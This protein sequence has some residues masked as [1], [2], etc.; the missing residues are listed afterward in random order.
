MKTILV[1]EDDRSIAAALGVRLKASGY[2]VVVAYDAVSG[3]AAAVRTRPDLVLLDLSMPGGG[4]LLVAERL[5][6]LAGTAAT[7]LIV[8]TASKDPSLRT[9]ATALGVSHFFEKPYDAAAL[10]A[11]IANALGEGPALHGAA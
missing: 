6:S 7:P 11:A 2:E 9:K 1:V 3:V 5:R 8:M 4:G 10:L